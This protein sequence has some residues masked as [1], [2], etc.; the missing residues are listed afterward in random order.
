MLGYQSIRAEKDAP[1]IAAMR[2]FSAQYPRYG[3]R[4]IRIFLGREGHHMGPE[5][6]HRLV[7]RRAQ[8]SRGQE[9]D[10]TC[11]RRSDQKQ[12]REDQCDEKQD[13]V[14]R[15]LRKAA[16]EHTTEQLE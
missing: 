13:W 11:R 8:E 10:H 14:T 6:A 5:R 3:Y 16:T 2:S 1:A 4:R 12:Q 7:S 9:V 15:H